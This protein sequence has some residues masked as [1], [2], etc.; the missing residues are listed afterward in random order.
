MLFIK[1]NK[2]D[3]GFIYS[4]KPC[5]RKTDNTIENERQIPTAIKYRFQTE[6]LTVPKINIEFIS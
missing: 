5:I 6:N 1:Y 4:F 3:K 2:K